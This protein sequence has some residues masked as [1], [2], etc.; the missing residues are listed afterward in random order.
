MSKKLLIVD[1][2]RVSRMI[3]KG[4][5]LKAHADWEVQ[6]SAN[7]DDALVKTSEIDFDGITIDVN[8]PG[9]DGITLAGLLREKCPTDKTTLFVL[10]ANIQDT[11]RQRAEAL[12]CIFIEKPLSAEKIKKVVST[13]ENN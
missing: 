10:T 5:I 3:I 11:I 8:M 12:G 6:E 13:L 1:D 4:E 2:S 7:A 9:M